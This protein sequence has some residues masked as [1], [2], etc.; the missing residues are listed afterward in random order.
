LD[1][2]DDDDDNTDVSNFIWS[3][4]SSKVVFA[5]VKSGV[6]SLVLVKM[7]H[8]DRDKDH[9]KDHDGDHDRD[10]DRDNDRP[11]TLTYSFVG[12]ENVCAG[13]A[14]CDSNNVRSIAWNGD[15]VNVALVQANPTGPSIVTNLTIPISKF[16]PLAK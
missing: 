1:L 3:V 10:H 9:D 5:D 8:S 2:E 16:V 15:T 11:R 13:A 12:A 7:P 6:I 14:T 4:D